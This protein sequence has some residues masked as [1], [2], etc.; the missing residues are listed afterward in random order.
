MKLFRSCLYVPGHRADRFERAYASEADAVILDLEDGVPVDRKAYARDAVARVTA[1]PTPKP[2][3]VRVNPP[4]GPLGEADVL[5]VA[6]AGLAG[7]R[8]A[9][10]SYPSE[11]RT[12]ESLLAQ[13][14]CDATIHLLIESAHALEIAYLLATASPTVGMLGLGESDLRADLRAAPEGAT[15]DAARARVIIASRAARLP[16]PCQSVFPEVR[17]LDG[18]LRTSLHGKELGF[19]GR[20]AIHPD[21][22][23]IIHDVY[24]PSPEEIAEARAICDAEDQARR[25]EAT[26]VITPSG[27]M[28]GP[29]IIANARALLDL[30]EALRRPLD[31]S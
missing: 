31:V 20:M 15:M 5:A 2:T 22:V 17:D 29:P 14:G 10:V 4:R 24:T 18:L 28:V 25:E 16:S 21:Q 7:V 11:V 12:V 23:P 26:I 19:V 1:Q 6:G 9:K 27:R 8:I 30:A 13:A 3:F